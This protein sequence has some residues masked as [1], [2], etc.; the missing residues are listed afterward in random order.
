MKA[1]I[2]SISLGLAFAGSLAATNVHAGDKTY[3]VTITNIT[4]SQIFTP[5][6]V[7]A[8]AADMHIYKLGEPATSELEMLAEGGDVAPLSV[9]LTDAGADVA[10]SGGVLTPG[11]SVTVTVTASKGNKY[12]SVASM[13]IPTNDSFFGLDAVRVPKRNR[14]VAMTSPAYDAGTETNSELCVEIPGP[15]SVCAGEGFNPGSGEGYV[16]VSEGIHGV[17]DLSAN[18]YDWRNPVASISI[19]R[20]K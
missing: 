12:I 7:A 5:I 13:L 18:V 19:R 15:P 1:W 11:S 17:G 6:L 3:E 9:L 10:D 16:H 20:V 4:K 14:T 2:Q 8:H